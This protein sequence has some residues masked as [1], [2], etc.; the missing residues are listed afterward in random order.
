MQ[1]S[2]LAFVYKIF[3]IFNT[4]TNLSGDPFEID[5]NLNII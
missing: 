1:I 5:K 2:M 3:S 4:F